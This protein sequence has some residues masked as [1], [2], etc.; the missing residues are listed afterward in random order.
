LVRRGPPS[1]V[2]LILAS[3]LLIGPACLAPNPAFRAT[4]SETNDPAGVVDAKPAEAG[5]DTG[6]ADRPRTTPDVPAPDAP[7]DSAAE[8]VTTMEA[9]EMGR[10]A[11]SAPMP[12]VASPVD[13]TVVNPPVEAGPATVGPKLTLDR[14]SYGVG[15]AI[16]ASFASGPGNATDWIGIYQASAPAPSDANRSIAWYYTNNQR[17]TSGGS[18]P[19]SGTVTFS[20]GTEPTW[21]LPAGAYKAIFLANDGYQVLAGPVPFDVR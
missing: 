1:Q 9:V 5:Q 17:G 19:R 8:D 13:M 4:V 6:M 18:G 3:L 16:M 12:E 15:Q 21:P 10:P 14:A 7:Q 20:A 11:D 2:C